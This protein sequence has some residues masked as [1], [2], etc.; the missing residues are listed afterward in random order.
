MGRGCGG[1]ALGAGP[2]ASRSGSAGVAAGVSRSSLLLCCSRRRN[3]APGRF[4]R[5]CQRGVGWVP[6]LFIAFVV[7][8]S[9]YAYVV[10]LC[11]CEYWAGDGRAWAAAAAVYG[12]QAAPRPGARGAGELCGSVWPS[13]RL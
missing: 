13:L 12:P 4:W 10:E 7:A 11:V 9:Y 1:R 8:W 5:C 2:R 6:V 3:M